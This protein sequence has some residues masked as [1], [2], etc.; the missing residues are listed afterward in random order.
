MFR[1]ILGLK[2]ERG[3]AVWRGGGGALY[4]AS[5]LGV[6]DGA[7]PISALVGHVGLWPDISLPSF[8][9]AEPL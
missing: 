5:H 7:Y 1:C 8:S 3:W 6:W 9:S 2:K 4:P